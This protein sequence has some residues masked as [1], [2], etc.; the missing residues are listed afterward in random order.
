MEEVNVVKLLQNEETAKQ[1]ADFIRLNEYLLPDP[2]S[3]HVDVEQYAKK[4]NSLGECWA[5]IKND[6]I[7]AF[8]GG[9]I[10]DLSTKKAFLQLL[11]VSEQWH[12]SGFGKTLIKTFCDYAE[13]LGFSKVQLTVAKR[14]KKALQL[15]KKIGFVNSIE[16]HPDNLKQYMILNYNEK[17][18]IKRIQQCLTGMGKIIANILENNDIPYMITFGTLLGAVRHKGFIPWDDD[19]DFFLFDDT[20]DKAIEILRKNLPKNMFLE[21]EKSEPL[22]F[23][24]WA[25]VKDVNT[26]VYCEQFPQDNLYAHHGLSVDLYRCKKMK[27]KNLC[28]FR[29]NE[30]KKYLDRK[31]SNN[32]ISNEEYGLKLS[33]L[34]SKIENEE[35]DSIGSDEEIFAMAVQERFMKSKD[36]FPLKRYVFDDEEFF[37][38]NNADEILKRFYGDYM[39]L[40]KQENRIPHYS[41]V[42]FID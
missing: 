19:F 11:L 31:L 35:K 36:V 37:G 2:Y 42:L 5:I 24:G 30:A 9:Y 28:K 26:E 23:H 39:S 8:C 27:L 3:D 13:K 34:L 33:A 41:K 10:N 18:D 21:D 12:G 20:Y 4:L 38:P 1:I 15:Y 14:N 25:H 7:V 40:P 32:L 16:E 29:E 6:E 17:I 22:Y